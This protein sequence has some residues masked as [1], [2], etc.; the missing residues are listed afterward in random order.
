MRFT[1]MHGTGNDF[2]VLDGTRFAAD[3]AAL[4]VP[5]N[6]RHFGVGG[7][8]LIVALP[9]SGADLRMRMFNPDGSEAEMCGNGIRCLAKYAVERG[10]VP[11]GDAVRIET[12]AGNLTCELRRDGGTVTAVRVSMGE[13]RLDPCEIPVLAEQ[14]PPVLGFP[15]R[16]CG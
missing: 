12:L 5:M 1:K 16:V 9:S 15:V 2:V 3:W 13:P 11:A 10:L 7:D 4:A 14:A 6:D 8:G